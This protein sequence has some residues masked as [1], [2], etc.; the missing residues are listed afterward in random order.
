MTPVATGLTYKEARALEQTLIT[1]YTL[2]ALGNAI[3]SIAEK[4]YINLCMNL[5]E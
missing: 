1:A 3:N 4:T 5:I 2:N